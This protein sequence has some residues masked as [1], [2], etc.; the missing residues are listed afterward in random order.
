MA[1]DL[2]NLPR[3]YRLTSTAFDAT[4]AKPYSFYLLEDTGVMHA[5]VE[6]GKT[7]IINDSHVSG[8]IETAINA[9]RA[10]DI[11]LSNSYSGADAT[12]AA[13]ASIEAAISTLHARIAS[14]AGTEGE[15]L[16]LT[17]LNVAV[18]ALQ[19][20]TAGFDG[21]NTVAKGIEDAVAD[22]VEEAK[23]YTDTEVAKKL[24]KGTVAASDAEEIIVV[25]ADG[26]AEA[27]GVKVAELVKESVYAADKATFALKSEI[28]DQLTKTEA[29][30]TYATKGELKVVADD[31][32]KAADKEELQG[33]INAKVAQD[34]YDAQIALLATKE[35]VKDQ[36]TKTEAASTY[37][38][39]GD[40]Y[41]K[42]EADNLLGG[43]VDKSAY[44]EQVALLA[45]KAELKVVT[46]DYLKAADKTKLQGNIDK[47][48]D[49]TVID[50]YS[51]TE[52]MNNAISGAINT[53]LSAVLVF[54]G[55]KATK[56]ELPTEGNKQGDVWVVTV[57][58]NNKE[59]VWTGTAWEELGDTQVFETMVQA[60]T[61]LTADKVILGNGGKNVKASE[62][63]IGGEESTS[64]GSAKTLATEA[65]V[66]ADFDA[67]IAHLSWQTTM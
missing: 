30:S 60:E 22:G 43:K 15:D 29:G 63:G 5:C 19:A 51:T 32:L 17:S 50:S 49:A 25:S 55:V 45:T 10:S 58:G 54:K 31:Y 6:A 1:F 46:D 64:A 7:F 66:K 47:K 42:A 36:L 37:A 28:A 35:E 4:K 13:G 62:F 39:I 21:T 57:E 11:E 12:I 27:S 20:A 24:G 48:L 14:L 9:L 65:A 26:N 59:F 33:K 53:A 2:S 8:L 40:A 67:I 16:D 34:D 61:D 41:T 44:D 38:K 23:G 56:E 3:F 52:A 18:L